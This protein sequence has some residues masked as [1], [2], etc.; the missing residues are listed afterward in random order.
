MAESINPFDRKKTA[1]VPP[2]TAPDKKQALLD[3]ATG[4]SALPP[5]ARPVPG[6]TGTPPL[7]TGRVVG[8]V[9]P[10]SYTAAE[11]AALDAV[12]YSEDVE[13][14]KTQ[15]GLKQ[16]QEIIA[17][18]NAVEVPLP[19]DPRTPPLKVNTVPISSLPP[20]KQAAV[21][22]AIAGIT[23]AEKTAAAKAAA[24]AAF[25]SKEGSVK[26]LGV[27]SQAA[28][29]A[30]EAFRNRVAK[31][32]PQAEEPVYDVPLSPPP[33]PG[34]GEAA[35]AIQQEAHDR[36]AAAYEQ[37]R[38]EKPKA[39]VPPPEYA[40][41]ATSDTG[42]AHATL[43]HCPH[44]QW[45]L[46]DVDVPEPPYADKMGFMHSVLGLKPFVKAYPLFNGL[47][48][49]TFRTLTT[50]EV[51]KV[52][53]QTYA[54]RDAGKLPTDW[55]YYERLNRYRMILQLHTVKVAGE[56]G[57]F[58]ELPDGYSKATNNTSS[59]VWVT[60]DQEAALGINKTGL[61]DIEEFLIDE[62]LKTE[63][64]FRTVNAQCNQFNRLCSKLEA[65]VDNS[66]FWKPTEAQS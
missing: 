64:V 21:K 31:N 13:L 48:D 38:V 49:V 56:N 41:Q 16:L 46:A 65:M 47:M 32:N 60:P 24:S 59:G 30:V 26:G 12:G 50:R 51:D 36:A 15:D 29:Q 18:H 35:A 61:P 27:A 4:K 45:D 42:A 37:G 62:I 22:S 33:T 66:D 9:S 39:P 8:H 3:R 5:P 20:E 54:D 40:A 23:Q 17:A 28:E 2:P 53:A 14:P 10:S 34:P 43:S 19:V 44:C 25:M 1:A 57:M 55:D 52:Y 7:P 11:R 63:H 6:V 58:K